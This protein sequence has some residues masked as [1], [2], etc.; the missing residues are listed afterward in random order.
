MVIYKGIL[1][2][3]TMYSCKVLPPCEKLKASTCDIYY[4]HVLSVVYMY[5]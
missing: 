1:L 3:A 2:D 4:L 5:M